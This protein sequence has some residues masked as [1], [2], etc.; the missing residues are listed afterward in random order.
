MV[1]SRDS[2]GTP[3]E[4]LGIAMDVTESR[5]IEKQ[6][7]ESAESYRRQFSENS[8]VMLLIDPDGGQIVEANAAASRFYGHTHEQLLG[9][10]ISDI[11][12]LS[13]DEVQN[14]MSSVKA[15]SGSRFEFRHALADG[16]IRDVDVSASRILFEGRTP[17]ALHHSRHHRS[18]ASRS[19]TRALRQNRQS[20]AD[21]EPPLVHRAR[22]P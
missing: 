6:A 17:A 13:E 18:Q 3:V 22:R 21:C 10:R 9:M 20:H 8:A 12:Q 19:G 4:V 7:R 1:F 14:A 15:E 2:E 16:S 11:S 5:S